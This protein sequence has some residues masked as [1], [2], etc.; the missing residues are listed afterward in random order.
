M[1]PLW[2]HFFFLL[3]KKMTGD[4]AAAAAS[5]WSW[6]T[7]C[8]EPNLIL[9]R[10]YGHAIG[11]ACYAC[12][13]HITVVNTKSPSWLLVRLSIHHSTLRRKLSSWAPNGDSRA[14][15]TAFSFLTLTLH[16]HLLLWS[17]LHLLGYD[18]S[19]C[20]SFFGCRSILCSVWRLQHGPYSIRLSWKISISNLPSRLSREGK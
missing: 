7:L 3:I 14:M 10:S 11:Y 18:L 12:C 16:L 1:S 17:V 5:S 8:S 9:H 2:A 15:Q 20:G 19:M 13:R 4:I 6:W